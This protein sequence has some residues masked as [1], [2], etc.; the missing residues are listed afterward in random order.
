MNEAAYIIVTYSLTDFERGQVHQLVK[1]NADRWWHQFPD[2]WIGWGKTTSFWRDL[3]KEVVPDAGPRGAIL[4]MEIGSRY[5]SFGTDEQFD[6]L[7]K[8]WTAAK[9]ASLGEPSATHED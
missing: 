6:G 7:E 1:S 4:V 9:T 5:A 2:V 3:I 8:M